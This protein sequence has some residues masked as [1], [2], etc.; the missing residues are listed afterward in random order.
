MSSTMI[1]SELTEQ[2]QRLLNEIGK[3]ESARPPIEGEIADELR[4]LDELGERWKA[5]PVPL[6]G[7][8]L[9]PFSAGAFNTSIEGMLM[10]GADS[11]SV[12][13]GSDGED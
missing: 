7:S 5:S 10:A 11:G 12:E 1:D 9:A 6:L 4:H 3:V 8:P 13:G 2:A